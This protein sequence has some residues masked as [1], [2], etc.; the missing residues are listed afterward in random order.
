MDTMLLNHA[1]IYLQYP[2][3]PYHPPHDN[4]NPLTA[5]QSSPWARMP[6]NGLMMKTSRRA[7]QA[8]ERDSQIT[9]RLS[10]LLGNRQVDG[11]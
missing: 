10:F 1:V 3:S 8:R 6:I 2:Q 9:T 11:R 5:K 7:T 4:E